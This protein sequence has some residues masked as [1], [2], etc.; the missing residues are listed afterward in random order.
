[1]TRREELIGGLEYIANHELLACNYDHSWIGL[2]PGEGRDVPLM[3]HDQR[4]W[5]GGGA[6]K[7]TTAR[8]VW[9]E[10]KKGKVH[11]PEVVALAKATLESYH[12]KLDAERAVVEGFVAEAVKAG[13]SAEM[14]REHAEREAKRIRQLGY[15]PKD[16]RVRYE[17]MGNESVVELS[18]RLD[19][20]GQKFLDH[21]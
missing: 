19:S 4:G 20:E 1:M 2:R 10:S 9:K 3:D 16:W 18:R 7:L 11:P 6:L 5:K 14:A 21:M 17:T 8:R 13:A 12:R 15:A